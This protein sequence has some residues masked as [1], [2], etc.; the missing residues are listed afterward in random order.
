LRELLEIDEWGGAS[1]ERLPVDW[2]R[3]IVA[4]GIA[5]LI[6]TVIVISAL[7]T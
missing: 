4:A 1:V 3:I 5:L 6:L 2:E 7:T